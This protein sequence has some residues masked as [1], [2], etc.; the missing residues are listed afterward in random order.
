MSSTRPP[1][2]YTLHVSNITPPT[3]SPA[4]SLAERIR[5][6]RKHTHQVFGLPSLADG[7]LHR[8]NPALGG[9]S[10][11]AL[12]STS[13]GVEAVETVLTRIEHGVYS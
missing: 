11:V 3:P 10:P 12:L 6:V 1:P 8:P 9:R 13:E 5:E 7:W 4:A 2:C